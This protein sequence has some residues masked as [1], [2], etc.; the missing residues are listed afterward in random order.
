MN[1]EP[2]FRKEFREE[3]NEKFIRWRTSDPDYRR[4][5]HCWHTKVNGVKMYNAD[6]VLK[7]YHLPN[8]RWWNIFNIAGNTE[9]FSEFFDRTDAEQIRS[10][11][12][13]VGIDFRTVLNSFNKGE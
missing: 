2:I 12:E 7:K 1:Q 10:D 8:I 13:N 6:D 4:A 3:P 5:I 11:W 9:S